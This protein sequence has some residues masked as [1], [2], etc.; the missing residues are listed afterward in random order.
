MRTLEGGSTPHSSSR[1]SARTSI[2]SPQRGDRASGEDSDLAADA[3][4]A[5]RSCARRP[6]RPFRSRERGRRARRRRGACPAGRAGWSARRGRGTPGA[7]PGPTASATSCAWPPDSRSGSRSASEPMASAP[8]RRVDARRRPRRAAGPGCAARTRPPPR[9]S[10]LVPD[11][12]VDGFWNRIPQRCASSCGSQRRRSSRPSID[13][14]AL[15]LAADRRRREPR[16]DE[17]EASTC[18]RRWRRRRPAPGRARRSRVDAVERRRWPRRRIGSAR[19]AA[20]RRHGRN[21]SAAAY[22]RGSRRPRATQRAR[23]QRSDPLAP[24]S[25]ESAG[26]RCADRAP[27]SRAPRAPSSAPRPR[28]G[29]RRSAVRR[30]AARRGPAARCRPRC[31]ARARAAPR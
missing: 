30:A 18:R 16:G 25:R 28:S 31:P 6:G 7:A 8:Q 19:R 22:R 27:R 24:A 4:P 20:T 11:S 12:W 23:S 2:A 5:D 15:Q 26:A 21:S 1:G 10:A 29:R 9:R 13:D 3:L 17:A 14:R